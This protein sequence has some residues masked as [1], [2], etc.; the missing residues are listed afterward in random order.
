QEELLERDIPVE[1]ERT[2]TETPDWTRRDLEHEHTVVV[3]AALGVDGPVPQTDR[4]RG[5][6]NRRLDLARFAFRRLGRRRVDLLFEERAL[7]R[8]RLVED[9]KHA[10]LAIREQRFDR[11]LAPGDESFDEHA[12]GI[13][14]T[15]GADVSRREEISQPAESDDE[16]VPVVGADDAPAAREDE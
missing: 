10:R 16:A 1:P 9:G 11:V 8:V 4:A 5:I 15:L 13:G 7:E 12:I 14:I 6:R 3:E 2:R